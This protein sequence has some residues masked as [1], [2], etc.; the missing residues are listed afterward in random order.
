MSKKMGLHMETHENHQICSLT[1]ADNN[2]IVSHS[3]PHLEQMMDLIE[4][5]CANTK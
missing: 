5:A 4:E 1:W 2:W 3:K